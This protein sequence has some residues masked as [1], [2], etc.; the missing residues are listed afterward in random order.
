MGSFGVAASKILAPSKVKGMQSALIVFCFNRKQAGDNITG[1]LS[2][3]LWLLINTVVMAVLAGWGALACFLEPCA[4]CLLCFAEIRGVFGNACCWVGV[5]L[6]PKWP[7]THAS[8]I[9]PTRPHSWGCRTWGPDMWNSVIC[10]QVALAVGGSE[11]TSTSQRPLRW[12]PDFLF[13]FSFS[14]F[15]FFP[16]V[17]KHHAPEKISYCALFFSSDIFSSA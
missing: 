16:A 2:L 6:H 10:M 3:A 7:C 8:P 12:Q 9:N 17:R 11:S 5:R 4:A 14:F 1:G 13:S 15:F